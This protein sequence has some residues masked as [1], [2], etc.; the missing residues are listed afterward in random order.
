MTEITDDSLN[1]ATGDISSREDDLHQESIKDSNQSRAFRSFNFKIA[2]AISIFFFLSVLVFS[3]KS[4][5]S[6]NSPFFATDKIPTKTIVN[7]IAKEVENHK[8]SKPAE[9][10]KVSSTTEDTKID[11]MVDDIADAITSK[12]ANQ[13]LFLLSLLSAIGLTLAIA[14][15]RFSAP[16]QK[17]D[18]KDTII[19]ISPIA[20]AIADFVKSIT[21]LIKKD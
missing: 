7:E 12:M 4:V 16:R 11:D 3:W 8:D 2:W 20:T 21:G 19:P 13:F 15:M 6:E 14:V 1:L 18:D 10:D 17:P 9:N 5:F